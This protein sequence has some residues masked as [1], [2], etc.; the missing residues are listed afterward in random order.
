[1]RKQIVRFLAAVVMFCVPLGAAAEATTISTV[2]PEP[3]YQMTI[4]ADVQ[5][6]YKAPSCTIDA[7]SIA[8]SSGFSERG[9]MTVAVS[10][11]GAFSCEN[12]STTIP[13]TF[14]AKTDGGTSEWV[15]GD[16]LVYDRMED[17]SVNP[18]GHM[19]DGKV[20]SAFELQISNDAWEKANPG[21]YTAAITFTAQPAFSE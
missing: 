19:S 16:K 20:P 9:Y 17:G 14:Y 11:S 12:T 8:Q 5:M 15:S 21:T 18:S 6:E 2:V 13:F 1:M 4:P 7:P 3:S 10:Y